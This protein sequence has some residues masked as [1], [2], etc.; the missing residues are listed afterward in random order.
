M[1]LLKLID[2]LFKAFYRLRDIIFW[3]LRKPI[4]GKIGWGSYIKSGVKIIGNPYRIKIGKNFKIWQNCV[5]SVSR[6]EIQI[7]NNGLLGVGSIIIGGNCQ[8]KIGN[9]VAI[10]PHCKLFACSHHYYNENVVTESYI[11]GDITINN[12][13]LIGAGVIILPNVN[14]GEGAVI[15]AGSV[16]TKNVDS[17]NIVGGVPAKIIKVIKDEGTSSL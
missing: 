14:I 7:G 12:N 10:A 17:N 5:I 9:N 13:V 6:G 11:E 15:A 3:V 2:I 1:N 8:V 16:V 4:I